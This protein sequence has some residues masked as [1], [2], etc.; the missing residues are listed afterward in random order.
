[1]TN[2]SVKK[3]N[4]FT[5]IE[6]AVAVFMLSV[7]ICGVL[8]IFP[9][10]LKIIQSSNLAT[11]AVGLAQEKIEGLSSDNYDDISIGTTSE[12][13]AS[14][15][16]MFTRQTVINY[17]DPTNGMVVSLIDTGIKKAMITISWNSVLS[18]G[19]QSITINGLMSK[20]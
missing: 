16:D 15:F 17:V 14:P 6:T 5:L 19:Q 8:I 10:S 9:L 18:I 12:N 20:H 4:G 11:K 3:R 7:G 13:L 2:I 1:M